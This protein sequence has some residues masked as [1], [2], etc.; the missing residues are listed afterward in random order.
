MRIASPSKPCRRAIPRRSAPCDH[1]SQGG[2]FGGLNRASGRGWGR[3]PHAARTCI[4]TASRDGGR[5]A[6]SNRNDGSGGRSTEL[7]GAV[8]EQG[9]TR[10][11]YQDQIPDFC[12]SPPCSRIVV[13]IACPILGAWGGHRSGLSDSPEGSAGSIPDPAFG[14]FGGQETAWLRRVLAPHLSRPSPAAGRGFSTDSRSWRGRQAL[15]SASNSSLDG[16][17]R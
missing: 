16:G 8:P 10:Q 17:A 12:G 9:I 3:S 1:R 11:F 6:L 7:P 5:A 4:R 14:R 15:A 13:R 2:R